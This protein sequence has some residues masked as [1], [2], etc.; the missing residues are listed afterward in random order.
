M[1]F[2]DFIKQKNQMCNQAP[3]QDDESCGECKACDLYQA[4]ELYNSS[5]TSGLGAYYG[6]YHCRYFILEH[7]DLAELAVIKW[8]T[9]N[10]L[11]TNR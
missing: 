2:Q 4:I 1:E 8:V 7:P 9:G 10:S 6:C 3:R 5:L 11:T